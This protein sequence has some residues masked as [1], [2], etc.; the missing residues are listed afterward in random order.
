MYVKKGNKFLIKITEGSIKIQPLFCRGCYGKGQGWLL[1]TDPFA[2]FYIE[3][4]V[5]TV[6]IGEVER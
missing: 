5:D 1:I 3:E 4:P 6:C 2:F